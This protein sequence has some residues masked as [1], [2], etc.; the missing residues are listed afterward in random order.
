[1]S[2][3]ISLKKKVIEEFISKKEER[4]KE[5]KNMQRNQLDDATNE[6]IDNSNL[7]DSSREQRMD[8]VSQ[9]SDSIDFVLHEIEVLKAIRL[10][11]E[12]DSVQLGALVRTNGVSFLIGAAQAP[13][14]IEGE[15]YAGLSSQAHVFKKMESLKQKA[16]FHYESREYVILEII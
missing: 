12:N 14:Q 13:F 5:L 16:E 15:T 11:H 10:D 7:V 4:L 2:I 9:Q 8:E 6:D 1:M 3:S